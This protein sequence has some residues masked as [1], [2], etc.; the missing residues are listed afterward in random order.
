VRGLKNL[1]GAAMKAYIKIKNIYGVDKIYP[2]C[3]VSRSLV[4]LMNTKTIPIEKVY[5]IRQL[6]IELLQ[7]PVELKD[8]L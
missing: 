1:K 3:D 2:D 7:R 5:W 4:N 8:L 6:G